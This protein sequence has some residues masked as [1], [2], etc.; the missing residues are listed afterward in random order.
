V[1][2]ISSAI[3]GVTAVVITTT[4]LSRALVLLLALGATGVFAGRQFLQRRRKAEKA[5]KKKEKESS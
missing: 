4:G 3:L 5:A 1:L 2:Y